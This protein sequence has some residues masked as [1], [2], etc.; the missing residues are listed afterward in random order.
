MLM[1]YYNAG[2]L[3]G[4]NATDAFSI[5]TGPAVNTPTLLAA[6]QLTAQVG[7]RLSPDAQLVQINL[8]AV[9]ITQALLQSAS[10]AQNQ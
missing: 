8:N 5:N 2:A 6:G 9:P 4:Q 10:P 1:T 3:Y 7:V